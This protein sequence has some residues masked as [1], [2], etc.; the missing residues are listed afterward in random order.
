MKRKSI[1]AFAVTVDG[2]SASVVADYVFGTEGDIPKRMIPKYEQ[3]TIRKY[4]DEREPVLQAI[5]D[6]LGSPTIIVRAA[7]I[8]TDLVLDEFEMMGYRYSHYRW[9]GVVHIH[10]QDGEHVMYVSDRIQS[11]N[12]V[13]RLAEAI[14]SLS[15][16]DYWLSSMSYIMEYLVPMLPSADTLYERIDPSFHAKVEAEYLHHRR[17]LVNQ[18][19]KGSLTSLLRL[20]TITPMVL[21]HVM[22]KLVAEMQNAGY[23]AWSDRHMLRWVN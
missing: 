7:D 17:I 16:E 3:R 6:Q 12:P 10:V 4:L 5:T 1:D 21:P 18:M 14:G 8:D 22:E 23:T 15:D 20:P 9:S 13:V 2:D 19:A 11:T